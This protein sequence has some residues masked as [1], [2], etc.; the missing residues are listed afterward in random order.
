MHTA[1][2]VLVGGIT[3]DSTMYKASAFFC[4][5]SGSLLL[6]MADSSDDDQ[7]AASSMLLSLA[8]LPEER[9]PPLCR[10]V[11]ERDEERVRRLL[12]EGAVAVDCVDAAG[13][14]P[15]HHAALTG[16]VA[17][18]DLLLSAGASAEAVN[19]YSGERPLHCAAR[20]GRPSTVARLL[21]KEVSVDTA[22]RDGSTALM[23][24]V[25]SGSF[26]ATK[27]LVEA[28]A[29]PILCNRHDMSAL[30]YAR[31]LSC[32]LIRREVGHAAR[33]WRLRSGMSDDTEQDES[34]SA[35]SDYCYEW[36]MAI[37]VE[38]V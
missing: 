24:A 22:A 9:M 27:A 29:D 3:G 18:L 30:G 17:L 10:A 32:T 2:E 26:L 16:S 36:P 38:S 15:V 12:S 8:M 4:L 33:E 11:S 25:C 5:V 28:G 14:Q 7:H 37:D 35:T 6:G 19:P 23:V 21:E 34:S 31:Q 20:G 13:M 1:H